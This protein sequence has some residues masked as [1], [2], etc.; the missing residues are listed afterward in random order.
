[1]FYY[2]SSWALYRLKIH[3]KNKRPLLSHFAKETSLRTHAESARVALGE[4]GVTLGGK[5][6]RM[7]MGGEGEGNRVRTDE[8]M[9]VAHETKE[10]EGERE[11][12]MMWG[13]ET[14]KE[15]TPS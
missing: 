15:R 3:S 1:M 5:G 7:A 6:K 14:R 13:S 9:V 10:M 8:V 4:G 11:E 12:G 2:S